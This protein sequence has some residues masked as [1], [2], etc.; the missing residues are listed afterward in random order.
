MTREE[1][2]GESFVDGNGDYATRT[3]HASTM[4]AAGVL[5]STLWP[6]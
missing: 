4:E 6:S 5:Q 1:E 2:K 3:T